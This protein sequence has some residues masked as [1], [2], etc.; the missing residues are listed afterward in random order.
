MTVI[1]RYCGNGCGCKGCRF[2][3]GNAIVGELIVLPLRAWLAVIAVALFGGLRMRWLLWR[4]S[5]LAKIRRLHFR[6]SR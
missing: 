4:K 5:Q 3:A 2:R 1:R 6:G